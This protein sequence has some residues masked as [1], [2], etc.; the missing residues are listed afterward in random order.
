[1][2]AVTILQPA[3]LFGFLKPKS[4][5][6][7]EIVECDLED[8]E[9]IE[10]A[11]GNAGVVVCCIGASEK[12]V[13]DVSGPYRIDFKAT[14]NLIDAG[15]SYRFFAYDGFFLVVF[16]CNG[17]LSKNSRAYYSIMNPSAIWHSHSWGSLLPDFDNG[18][19]IKSMHRFEMCSL[20]KKSN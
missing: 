1:M 14:A 20:F 3:K 18:L 6:V 10:P 5:K 7:L 19:D 13:L 8:A 17:S 16:L 12:E 9:S 2:G 4:G 15:N 11:L